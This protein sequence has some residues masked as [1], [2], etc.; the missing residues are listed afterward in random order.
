MVNRARLYNIMH[1]RELHGNLEQDKYRL[2]RCIAGNKFVLT[3]Y[4]GKSGPKVNYTNWCVLR[5]F[6]NLREVVHPQTIIERESF[7]D[8]FKVEGAKVYVP[9]KRNNS[10]KEQWVLKP[11]EVGEKPDWEPEAKK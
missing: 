11:Y 6:C 9:K 1:G 7:T 8:L 2:V 3:Y 5:D 4:S 10:D